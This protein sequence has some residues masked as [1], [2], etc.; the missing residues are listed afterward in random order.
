MQLAV[1]CEAVLGK[2]TTAALCALAT[3][4]AANT[5]SAVAASKMDLV[6]FMVVFPVDRGV[7]ISGGVTGL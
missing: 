5:P 4:G 1:G 6:R 2:N 3:C 7:R